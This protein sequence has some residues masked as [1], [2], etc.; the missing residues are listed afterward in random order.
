MHCATLKPRTQE[1]P[2]LP[3]SSIHG[4]EWA[5]WLYYNDKVHQELTL[6]LCEVC[7]EA[8]SFACTAPYS[9]DSLQQQP[10]VCAKHVRF[11]HLKPTSW[12]SSLQNTT[13]VFQA[14]VTLSQ[15]ARSPDV[16]TRDGLCE[17]RSCSQNRRT[18]PWRS[19][20][21]ISHS[22]QSRVIIHPSAGQTQPRQP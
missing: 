18:N 6:L 13:R 10:A 3:P 7:G 9:Q 22:F 15:P 1:P 4:L 16:M 20:L 17:E 5:R 14:N 19:L 21:T 2:K 11:I 12:A 8:P